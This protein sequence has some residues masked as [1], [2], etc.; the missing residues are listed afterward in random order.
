[1]DPAPRPASAD[2]VSARRPEPPDPRQLVE[3]ALRYGRHGWPVLPLHT[4][5]GQGCSCS[6]SECGSRGK[7]PRTARGLHEAST[8]PGRIRSWWTRWPHANVG[9][10]TGAV[11]GLIVVDV[12]LPDGPDSLAELEAQHGSLPATCEQR[13]GSGGRQLLLTHPGPPVGNRA[14]VVPGIDVRGDGG[15]IVVPPSIHATGGRY[16]WVGRTPPATAPGWLLALPDRTR[17]LERRP[18]RDV[19]RPPLLAG[20]RGER[21][22][23]AAMHDELA[24]LAAA[25]EGTRNAT[26][27]RAAFSLGQLVATGLLD[28]ELVATELER[29]AADIGLGQREI[30]RTVASG[31]AAGLSQPRAIPDLSVTRPA[32]PPTPTALTA[33]VRRIGARRR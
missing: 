10:A 26:L 29:V 11:S 1:M 13:T 2:L 17:G 28:R 9:V 20:G 30:Q 5:G 25:V 19:P 23:T 14:G 6:V 22:A 33:P 31:L 8:D 4:P 27:N 24:G 21:Y 16:R 15:Y 12:D 18:A 7:H 3:V 32:A